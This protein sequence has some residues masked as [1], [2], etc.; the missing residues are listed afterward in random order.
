MSH[1]SSEHMQKYGKYARGVYNAD[2]CLPL[3]D[4]RARI[5]STTGR[6]R[7]DVR[8]FGDNQ[9]MISLGIINAGGSGTMWKSIAPHIRTLAAYVFITRSK[10]V[11]AFRGKGSRL[12]SLT[13]EVTTVRG[14][15]WGLF[16][17]HRLAGSFTWV[18]A[19][20]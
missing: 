20:H 19:T 18:R 13:W 2:S 4:K 3:I 11:V 14:S 7:L 15:F 5:N 9:F 10:T 1:L 12:L 16:F 8:F 17:S 6:K